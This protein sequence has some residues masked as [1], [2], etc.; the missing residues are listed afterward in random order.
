MEEKR[1]CVA[2]PED[3]SLGSLFIW[4]SE[5]LNRITTDPLPPYPPPHH[6]TLEP[7]TSRPFVM[8]STMTD[9]KKKIN[10]QPKKEG[11]EQKFFFY[12][13]IKETKSH[14]A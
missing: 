1:G 11:G 8:F 7:D 6:P 2:D 4:S 12:D 3:W 5:V 9:R 13:K 14:K 10:V